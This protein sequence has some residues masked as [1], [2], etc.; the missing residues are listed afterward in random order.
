MNNTLLFKITVICK[1]KQI[2]QN[3]KSKYCCTILFIK[4]RLN[5]ID[6]WFSTYFRQW[7]TANLTFASFILEGILNAYKKSQYE[8]VVAFI[9]EAVHNTNHIETKFNYGNIKYIT[10]KSRHSYAAVTDI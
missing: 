4:N 10:N 5:K 8:Y 7:L 6:E 3:V 9:I 2:T 1:C